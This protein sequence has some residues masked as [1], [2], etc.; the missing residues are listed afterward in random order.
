MSWFLT[1]SVMPGHDS[2]GRWIILF[3]IGI[4]TKIYTVSSSYKAITIFPQTVVLRQ[5]PGKTLADV[6]HGLRVLSTSLA[7]LDNQSRNRSAGRDDRCHYWVEPSAMMAFL[8]KSA[9]AAL[10]LGASA[11]PAAA[12]QS[13]DG[14]SL[15]WPLALP[16]A[17][18]LLS[19][20]FGPLAVK[21]W[22]HIHYEKAAGF[23]SVL[24]L[25]GLAASV[26]L[27]P[28]ALLLCTASRPNICPSFL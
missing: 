24:A 22:W 25:G 10:S 11:T 14:A 21:E 12:A 2:R 13:L 3:E 20:A 9:A 17:G 26:G 6:R 23:W 1:L 28:A 18:M 7:N 5:S 8:K 15:P 19:I 16:F 27:T 4:D